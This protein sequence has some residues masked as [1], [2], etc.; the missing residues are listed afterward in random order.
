MAKSKLTRRANLLGAFVSYSFFF[1]EGGLVF[2][3]TSGDFEDK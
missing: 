2:T 1:L 3:N